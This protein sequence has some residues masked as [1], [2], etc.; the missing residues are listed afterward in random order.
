ML[1]YE[2]RLALQGLIGRVKP[3]DPLDG[4]HDSQR[5]F[6]VD[7]ARW[8]TA[9]CGR[10]AGKTEVDG[11]YLAREARAD[12]TEDTICLYVALT[13]P[14]AKRQMWGR[15][16]SLDQRL[17]LRGEHSNQDLTLTL[18]GGALIW[19]TGASDSSDIEKLRGYPFKL[20]I[21]DEAA[22]FGPF[23]EEMV[24][25]VIEPGLEDYGGTLCMTGTPSASCV[26]LFHDATRGLLV[27]DDGSA[28]YSNHDWTVLDNP[29]FPRW[30]DKDPKHPWR[31]IP[32]KNWRKKAREWLENLRKE[33][34]WSTDNPIY[35]RE[36]LG[37]WIKH[38]E[39]LVYRYDA[40]KNDY[41]RLPKGT[42]RH[43]LGLDLGYDDLTAWVVWAF[44][45]ERPEAYCVHQEGSSG[46]NVAEV[47]RRT[48]RIQD[49]YKVAATVAD[50][51][52][53]GKMIVQEMVQRYHLFIE[54]AEKTAKLDHIELQNSDFFEGMAKVQR[55]SPYAREME[56]LQWDPDHPGKE[57][58]RF[59][60]HYCDAGLYG[61]RKAYHWLH[62]PTVRRIITPTMEM[63]SYK[64][65]LALE[66][67]QPK[68][69]WK[70]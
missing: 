35:Q 27:R 19:L 37:Q 5:K 56:R 23:F 67:N 52:G 18:P 13:R 9:K 32:H 61:W 25:E 57:D 17:Q 31:R 6:I 45:K 68:K 4:L 53:L 64:A 59:P 41:T 58:P 44:C 22:S 47:A 21:L 39:S 33:K 11:R 28:Q 14:T 62:R 20:V 16:K 26:G 36:W 3:P 42:W 66:A 46:L 30:S 70:E 2:Q 69:W 65:G 8:K 48:K 38:L 51:G 29:Y 43:V 12:D 34:G 50:T 7:P 10:R 1:S 40:A 55:D 63:D 24:H 54:P 49:K 60:N 15:I